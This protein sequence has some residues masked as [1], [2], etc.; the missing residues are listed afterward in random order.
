MPVYVLIFLFL[1][2]PLHLS[3]YYFLLVSEAK[4]SNFHILTMAQTSLVT[5]FESVSHHLSTDVLEPG[6]ASLLSKATK[7]SLNSCP[8]VGFHLYTVSCLDHM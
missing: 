3:V 1:L 8:A 5:T 2:N 4:P 6:M 7:L